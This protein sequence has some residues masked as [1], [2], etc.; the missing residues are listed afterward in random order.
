MGILQRIASAPPPPKPRRIGIRDEKVSS[1]WVLRWKQ[2]VGDAL[3][4]IDV[5][6]F[7]YPEI[8]AEERKGTKKSTAKMLFDYHWNFLEDTLINYPGH[9]L[10]LM[11]TSLGSRINCMIAWYQHFNITAVVCLGYHYKEKYGRLCDRPIDQYVKPTIFIQ[12]D[13][14]NFP[15]CPFD[16]FDSCFGVSSI[17]NLLHKVEGGDEFLQVRKDVLEFYKTTQE[18]VERKVFKEIAE[19][20]F[21]MIGEQW[22]N[23]SMDRLY[24]FAFRSGTA[25]IGHYMLDEMVCIVGCTEGISKPH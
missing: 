10:I 18:E 20:V 22:I 24:A 3:N 8:S 16:Q 11:G 25:I 14:S 12:R 4:A 1:D 15:F 23:S 7:D 19:Y 21:S 5:V 9:P 13:L 2:M 17:C 6:L